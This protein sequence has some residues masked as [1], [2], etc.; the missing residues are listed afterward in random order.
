MPSKIQL[1]GGAFQDSEGG[2]LANG[3]LKFRLSQDASVSS[4]GNICSGVEITIQLDA[5][6]NVVVSPAQYVWGN[7]NLLPT[8]TFYRVT[9]YTAAGQ[10]AW[11]PNNQQIQGSGTFDLGTWI[12]N[13]VIRWSPSIQATQLEVN[14]TPN[15]VQTLLNLEAG[16]N[17]TL[18]DEGDGGVTIDVSIP[19]GSTFEVG[20]T[21]LTSQAVVN[22]QAGSGIGITNPS[23]GNVAIANTAPGGSF[24]TATQAYMWGPGFT[25]IPTGSG[26]TTISPF[27]RIL[28]VFKF[29]LPVSMTLRS[30]S[31]Y[32][33]N[34][35]GSTGLNFGIY[36]VNGNL[37]IDSGSFDVSTNANS[38]QTLNFS[39]VTLPPGV[40]YFAQA[41]DNSGLSA[42]NTSYLAV[43]SGSVM[44]KLSNAVAHN[45]ATAANLKT[46]GPAG[47][48]PS[49]LGMLTDVSD[50][51]TQSIAM[52]LWTP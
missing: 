28:N 19:A 29:V 41:C 34:T 7:D 17:V 45:V 37:L 35:I 47:V 31:Y 36:D 1:T 52:P 15:V 12:P 38:V 13:Q 5:S 3:Y 2:V 4:V 50:V 42:P 8:N 51:T 33:T 46:A 22:F 6:G 40:Y 48:L 23:A 21:H 10:P 26:T 18:T 20:G 9:G 49:T 30:C 24:S 27:G 43:I 39:A 25:Q 14:D 11:G 44:A 32:W 16:T